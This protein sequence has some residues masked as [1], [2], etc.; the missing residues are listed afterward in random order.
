MNI[1][2]S[3]RQQDHPY[4]NKIKNIE[5]NM[6]RNILNLEISIC[7]W[8]IKQIELK[9]SQLKEDIMS[10]TPTMT[11][12]NFI[13]TQNKKLLNSINQNK[14]KC[15]SKFNRRFDNQHPIPDF[16]YD[17]D[18]I[19]NLTNTDVPID[20]QMLLSFGPNFNVPMVLK[21]I[22]IPHVLA[23]L[24]L[25]LEQFC[26]D[27]NT[28]ELR[29]VITTQI[30]NFLKTDPKLNATEKYILKSFASLEKFIRN[31]RD[32]VILNSDKSKKT[33]IMKRTEYFSKMDLLLSDN[34]TYQ[35]VDYDPLEELIKTNTKLVTKLYNQ[36]HITK[37]TR[38]ELND[39]SATYARI[40][41]LPKL[42]K[43][44][45]PL[46]P[47]VDTINSPSYALN[48]YM[49]NI[50]KNITDYTKYNVKNSY[51]FKSFIANVRVP[52]DHILVSFDVVSL[53]TN[54]DITKVINILKRRWSEIEIH[55]T[56]DR[57]LF[58]EALEFC[59][60]A[61]TYFKYKKQ[62]YKQK[63]GLGMGLSLA[64]TLSDIL[65]TDLFDKK[66]QK[67][68][69]KP[70]FLKKFIDDI[71]TTAPIEH[72]AHTK[73]LLRDGR[74]EFTFETEKENMIN[75]LD[76][77]LIHQRNGRIIT[78]WYSKPT[79]SNR[80]LNYLS[81][82]PHRMKWSIA[83]STV[84]KILTL[85]DPIFAR[86]NIEKIHH[87]LASNNYPPKI[88]ERAIQGYRKTR[89]A[90]PSN[91]NN[92]TEMKPKY[93]SIHYVPGLSENIARTF[94]TSIPDLTIAPKPSK[95]LKSSYS[96]MKSRIGKFGQ[97]N[98]IYNIPCEQPT[99]CVEDHYIGNTGRR[100]GIRTGEHEHDYENRH[101][102]G[103]KTALTRHALN[104]ERELK[105]KHNPDFEK[106]VIIDREP[107]KTKR[108][109]I[110]ACYIWLHGNRSNNFVRDKNSLHNN[111]THI[112]NTFKDIQTS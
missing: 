107:N 35:L 109:F 29:A 76:L 92:T 41:G 4:Q 71:I 23:D 84:R 96:N 39:L 15:T 9:R 2:D 83:T 11:A 51:E 104:T 58:F 10:C 18:C 87:I 6:C 31:N 45:I 3:Q 65:L 61:S 111:Y 93:A 8:Q 36:G 72:V 44:G 68:N 69:F 32:V 86:K 26:A 91:A 30:T 13:N 67:F 73:D 95:K 70:T 38:I 14:A 64:G 50:I 28:D 54:T 37:E 20:V 1:M 100:L 47:V 24:E 74:L 57:N 77:T 105:K 88:I 112:I 52:D 25:T 53:Y 81:S 99:E 75:F 27:G 82:H 48:K 103:G 46:R 101:M 60:D 79:T 63:F 33:V 17:K 42:H 97:R 90:V 43:D 85:S 5:K 59:I 110:E 22:P 89:Q 94:H 78:N 62:I 40:H 49:N 66:I 106:T 55:T 108:E 34:D 102:T 21:D 19:V 98:V 80:V 12:S 56:M 7:E 16:I